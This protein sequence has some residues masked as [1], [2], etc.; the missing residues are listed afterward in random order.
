MGSVVRRLSAV[1]GLVVSAAGFAVFAGA[2]VGVWWVKAE[3]NRKTDA[4]AVRATRRSA[5]PTTRSG[6]CAR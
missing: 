1:V 5:R 4:L 6:S 3:T 2:A